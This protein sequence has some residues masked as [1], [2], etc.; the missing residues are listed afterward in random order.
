MALACAALLLPAAACT[1]E[2]SPDP[3]DAR[4]ATTPGTSTAPTSEPSAPAGAPSGPA[5]PSASSSGPAPHP[6]SLPALM[7]REY[8]G[9][10]LRLGE[11]VLSTS[12]QTQY[13]VTYR[14]GD[15]RI[16]GRM[17]VPTGPGPFPTVV[18]AHGYID[19]AYYVNG[20]GM[21]R[22]RAWFADRGYVALHVDYRNHAESDV[23]ERAD[24]RL[25]LGYTEDVINAVQA[26]RQWDGPVD[27]GRVALVGRSMGGGV[28]YNALTVRP[29]LVDAGVVFAPVSSDTVDNFDRWTRGDPG[30]ERIIAAYGDPARPRNAAFWAATS[31]RSYFGRVTEPVLIHHGTSDDTCPIGWSR[32]TA[33]AMRTDGVEVTLAVYE[34][35]EHAFGPQFLDSMERTD[36]FLRQHFA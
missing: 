14:S 10:G 4:S 22:E 36:R 3:V 28:V 30:S 15:L 5:S 6:V 8:D 2:E 26:L 7:R 34:G 27:D 16:S 24:Q 17:A 19:P 20:Q 1:G 12:T 23:D 31:P 33:R 9:G 29:G 21:T 25:R 35:E 13:H 11:E 32:A 18:L